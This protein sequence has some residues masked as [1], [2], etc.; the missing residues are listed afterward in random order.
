LV[1]AFADDHYFL[2]RAPFAALSTAKQ[3]HASLSE[4]DW[5]VIGSIG[6]I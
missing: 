5:T 1:V 3:A 6:R 4:A 2:N